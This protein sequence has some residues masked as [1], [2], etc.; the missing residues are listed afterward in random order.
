MIKREISILLAVLLVCLCAACGQ[1]APL[2]P[3]TDSAAAQ[4]TTE[5]ETAEH[6]QSAESEETEMPSQGKILIAYFSRTGNTE[7]LAEEIQ[8]RTGGELFEIVPVEPYP[9][10]YDETV[11]RFRR[12]ENCLKLFRWNLIRKITMKP[13]SVSAGKGKKMPVL[14]LRK[15]WRIW[16]P[17]RWYLSVSQ[18]GAMICHTLYIPF[19][20]NMTSQVRR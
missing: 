12:A 20:S 14:R 7:E 11:E 19:W 9:E 16:I 1:S 15:M 8:L 18:I 17:M 6:T 5:P 3:E 4:N 2:E 13:W 10:D